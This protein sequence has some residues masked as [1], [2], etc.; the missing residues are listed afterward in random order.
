MGAA[1]AHFLLSPHGLEGGHEFGVSGTRL[2]N[3]ERL[4]GTD[5]DAHSALGKGDLEWRGGEGWRTGLGKRDQGSGWV[6]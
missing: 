2:R 1:P 4:G 6:A 3:E 5:C